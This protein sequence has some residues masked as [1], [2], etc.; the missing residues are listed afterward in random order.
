MEHLGEIK[1]NQIDDEYEFWAL[2]DELF[3]DKSGFCHNRTAILKAYMNGNLYG[4]RAIETDLMYENRALENEIYCE[5]SFYLLPC[6]C[7]KENNEAIIIWTHS[8]ARRMGF[9]KKLV[10]LLDITHA[11]NPLPDSLEFWRK[12]NIET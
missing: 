12:C 7:I 8:R 3:H 1:L 10:N 5:N 9:A 11:Y 6:F 4:L 2:I